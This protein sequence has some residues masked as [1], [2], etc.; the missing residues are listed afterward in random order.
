[1][2]DILIDMRTGVVQLGAVER[3][4]AEG[5]ENLRAAADDEPT[6]SDESERRLHEDARNAWRVY[7]EV[8]T[9]G[10]AGAGGS[11]AARERMVQDARTAWMRT[12]TPVSASTRPDPRFDALGEDSEDVR[13]RALAEAREAWHGGSR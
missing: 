4:D 3:R 10:A 1:M 7:D 6:R 5:E 13:A 12:S 9:E 8:D 2:K 11:D